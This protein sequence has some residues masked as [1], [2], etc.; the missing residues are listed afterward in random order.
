MTPPSP[1]ADNQRSAR[2]H[3]SAEHRS[4]SRD[5]ARQPKGVASGPFF[6]LLAES[7]KFGFSGDDENGDFEGFAHDH[8]Y[9]D[10]LP[11]GEGHQ[12]PI[13]DDRSTLVSGTTSA[14]E[15]FTSN[16]KED[17]SSSGL[18][19]E[20]KL[21]ESSSLSSNLE[22]SVQNVVSSDD[23]KQPSSADTSRVAFIAETLRKELG[24][25][26]DDVLLAGEF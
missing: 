4:D 23:T 7:A 15:S 10:D 1:S 22:R 13:S 16:T 19:S 20:I 26:E 8:E 17:P 3:R 12:T 14:P 6:Q 21:K 24:V 2:H 9:N 25:G 11:S 5:C 18:A